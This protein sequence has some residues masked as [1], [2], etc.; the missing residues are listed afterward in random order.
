MPR[1]KNTI[2]NSQRKDIDI[3]AKK[4]SE[5]FEKEFPKKYDRSLRDYRD[6]IKVLY[7]RKYDE[8]VSDI[9]SEKNDK[10]FKALK[11]GHSYRKRRISAF[12]DIAAEAAEKYDEQYPDICVEEELSKFCSSLEIRMPDAVDEYEDITV[13]AALF[14]LDS[15]EKSGNYDVA[16]YFIPHDERIEDVELPLAFQDSVF[17]NDV[18]KG[19]VYLIKNRHGSDDTYYSPETASLTAAD[20]SCFCEYRQHAPVPTEKIPEDIISRFLLD[21]YDKDD[22]IKP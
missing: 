17:S 21:E 19:V 4:I 22:L 16:V 10:V 3:I 18:I 7:S 13:A 15:I 14:I 12:V 5:T 6:K 9:K 1:K 2:H 8:N 20:K 11:L